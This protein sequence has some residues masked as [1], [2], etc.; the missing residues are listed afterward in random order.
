M[1]HVRTLIV[2]DDDM[3]VTLLTHMLEQNGFVISKGVPTEAIE[4]ARHGT[5][6]LILMDI[7]LDGQIDGI[8]AAKIIREF[9]DIPIVFIS[10]YTSKDFIQRASAVRFS[11]Y[12][13]KPFTI[14]QLLESVSTLIE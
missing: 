11:A 13:T 8:E 10:G 6:D 2:D 3:T 4:E 12:V 9:T 7:N 1:D 5:I 14:I